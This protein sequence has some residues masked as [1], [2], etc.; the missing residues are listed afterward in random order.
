MLVCNVESF[1]IGAIPWSFFYVFFCWGNDEYF[2][3]ADQIWYL[4][5]L[6]KDFSWVYHSG[7]MSFYPFPGKS[8]TLFCW[9]GSG[10]S[11]EFTFFTSPEES[12]FTFLSYLLR[13][14]QFWDMMCLSVNCETKLGMEKYHHHFSKCRTFSL[15]APFICVNAQI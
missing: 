9:D 2:L 5:C 13:V 11:G 12:K 4:F 15:I 8:I 10:W 6:Y 1:S 3:L 14:W 7:V